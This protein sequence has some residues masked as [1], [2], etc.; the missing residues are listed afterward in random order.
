MGAGVDRLGVALHRG[1]KDLQRHMQSLR[2]AVKC[3]V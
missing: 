2:A 1:M 3:G